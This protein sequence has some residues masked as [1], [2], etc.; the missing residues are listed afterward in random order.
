MNTMQF[1]QSSIE[2]NMLKQQ[3]DAITHEFKKQIQS[4]DNINISESQFNNNPGILSIKTL[5]AET[6]PTIFSIENEK[7][8]IKQGSKDKEPVTISPIKIKKLVFTLLNSGK[9]P[10]IIQID[11]T[12]DHFNNELNTKTS[13]A[14][15]KW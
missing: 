5:S 7:L 14:I 6:N 12:L 1:E 13:Y 4:A 15:R 3:S 10:G 9:T 8:M 11:L 2:T